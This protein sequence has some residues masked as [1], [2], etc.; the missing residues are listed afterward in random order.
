MMRMFTRGVL[1][2][3]RLDAPLLLITARLSA[4]QGRYATAYTRRYECAGCCPD[5]IEAMSEYRHVHEGHTDRVGRSRHQRMIVDPVKGG[6][7]AWLSA[8]GFD[9]STCCGAWASDSSG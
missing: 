4:A 7:E 3:R 9:Y 6:P 8:H 2:Y 5:E 1:L